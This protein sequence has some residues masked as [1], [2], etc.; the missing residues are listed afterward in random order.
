MGEVGENS[1][2][3]TINASPSKSFFI[4]TLTKD[5]GL[6]GA[7]L[8]LIDNSIDSYI[9]NSFRDRGKISLNYS[10]DKFVLEDNCGGIKKDKVYDHV[11]RFGKPSEN[12]GKTIG[13]YG[14]GLKRAILKIGNNILIEADDGTE[15]YSIL[16]DEK[17]LNEETNW[18][19][20]FKTQEEESV[21]PS[22][23]ITIT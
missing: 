16:I 2:G 17:W 5:I 15:K 22:T 23:R 20:N 8:D 9:E 12:R 3:R 4:R 19:L 7:I 18:D 21:S 6:I 13:T 1:T 14:I 10:K 11:F